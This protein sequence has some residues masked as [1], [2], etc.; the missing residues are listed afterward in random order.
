[1]NNFFKNINLKIKNNTE[2]SFSVVFYFLISLEPQISCGDFSYYFLKIACKLLEILISLFNDH[3]Y[4]H[5]SKKFLNFFIL[6]SG[7][8][9]ISL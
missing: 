9:D 4:S 3:I 1:M 5:S 8:L 7:S 6:N 2:H